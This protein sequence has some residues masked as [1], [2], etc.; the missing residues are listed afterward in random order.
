[1]EIKFKNTPPSTSHKDTI[2]LMYVAIYF[3]APHNYKR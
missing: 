2:S 3:K 1:M